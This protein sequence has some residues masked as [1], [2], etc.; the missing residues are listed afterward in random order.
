MNGKN[1]PMR[2]VRIVSAVLLLATMMSA[3]S[4]S[5]ADVPWVFEGSTNRVAASSCPS[6]TIARFVRCELSQMFSEPK[7]M[8]TRLGMFVIVK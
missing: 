1:L 6:E 2:F 7:T 8:S 3:A 4:L 5:G